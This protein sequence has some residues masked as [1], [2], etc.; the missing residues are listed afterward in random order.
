MIP[1]PTVPVRAAA[2]GW[3]RLAAGLGDAS[4]LESVCVGLGLGGMVLALVLTLAQFAFAPV[5][6]TQAALRDMVVQTGF[7]AAMCPQGWAG[8]HAARLDLTEAEVTA[9]Y[10]RDALR[11]SDAEVIASVGLYV[12]NPGDF[13]PTQGAARTRNQ[14]LLCIAESRR[15]ATPLRDLVPPEL[16]V[17]YVEACLGGAREML[18]LARRS[19]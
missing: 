10:L 3:S 15:L 17:G 7:D 1:P 5:I 12:A 19:T 9:W 2:T 16:R 13:V 14:I 8:D 6:R 18:G 4:R 11:L